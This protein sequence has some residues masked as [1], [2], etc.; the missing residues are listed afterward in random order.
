MSNQRNRRRESQ[1]HQHEWEKTERT[2]DDGFSYYYYI[3]DKCHEVRFPGPQLQK[4]QDYSKKNLFVSVE[5]WAL[6]LLYVGREFE[7]HEYIS[8]ATRYQKMLFLIFYEEALR[9]K[10]PTENPGFYGYKYGPYSDRI[11]EA[12]NFLIEEGYIITSGRKSSSTE[13]FIITAKGKERAK[14]I[15]DKLSKDQQLALIKF[16]SH[17]NQKTAKAICKYIYAKDEYKE[18]LNESLILSELFPGRKLYRRG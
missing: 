14:R 9:L 15:F 1:N 12:I 7:G 17:W 10:I 8:G 2:L 4:I 13:R 16:R 5:E 3:C 18:F 6:L 11:D